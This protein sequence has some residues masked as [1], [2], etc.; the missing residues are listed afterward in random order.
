MKHRVR[1][2]R[3]TRQRGGAGERTQ[4]HEMAKNGNLG[5]VKK[6]IAAR[7]D[8]INKQDDK[9]RTALYE[10][11][12]GGHVEVVKELIA[13]GANMNLKT[14]V[15]GYTPIIVALIQ[16]HVKVVEVLLAAGADPNIKDKYG[17]TPLQMAVKKG[18]MD[19]VQALIAAGADLNIKYDNGM[20]PLNVALEEGNKDLVR[21]FIDGGADININDKNGLTPLHIAIEKGY[22]DIVQK[23][24]DHGADVHKTTIMNSSTLIYAI[25]YKRWDVAL[26]L[27]AAGVDVNLINRYQWN[28]LLLTV[29][30]NGPPEVV[31]ALITAGANV[32]VKQPAKN[33]S[34]RYINRY[35]P[36]KDATSL[37]YA[38]ATGNMEVAELLIAAGADVNV[39]SGQGEPPLII[40]I[41]KGHI[42]VAQLLISTGADINA[43]DNDGSTPA[44]LAARF[45]QVQLL[46]GLLRNEA[47]N[48]EQI[49]S[50]DMTL[51]DFT[52]YGHRQLFFEKGDAIG[53][54]VIA[55]ITTLAKPKQR[56]WN[57][58]WDRS[59]IS[60]LDIVFENAQQDDGKPPPSSNYACCPV[61]LK[62]TERT[63]G[64]MYVLDHNCS[65]SGG[66]YHK[67]LYEKYKH[68]ATGKIMWCALCGRI[69][70]DHRHYH[71]APAQ[72]AIPERFPADD[73]FAPDCRGHIGGGGLPEKVAR[74][75]TL[76]EAFL[77]HL[78]DVD[79][80]PYIQVL[81]E[82]IEAAWNAPLDP[83]YKEISA[84][85]LAEKKWDI[86]LDI[87][88]MSLEKEE[89]VNITKLPDIVKPE[90]ERALV[91]TKMGEG[92]N[93]LG[94]DGMLYK[95]HNHVEETHITSEGLT[96][97]I[98]GIVDGYSNGTDEES[99]GQ[100]F[101][102]GC[103]HKL[104]PQ[105]IK[106][107][108]PDDLYN[109]Y[110]HIFNFKFRKLKG[111]ARKSHKRRK[112]QRNKRIQTKK[113]RV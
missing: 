42:D 56:M 23:L 69:A 41:A 44:F 112:C 104:Y 96:Y 35:V 39:K 91:P 53:K 59:D 15:N 107:I 71:V 73:Y 97:Y 54:Q 87:F 72:G 9:G 63:E 103:K 25:D 37:H 34:L 78:E 89:A 99:L 86:P 12:S 40:S 16:E 49:I 55:L 2:R 93:F 61:C 100:C 57:G 52:N 74:F 50:N 27:I 22:T 111:G 8:I 109:K 101:T 60:R 113:R 28:P 4:L 81:E 46:E 36:V 5:D 13:A 75:R 110:R 31:K 105:D 76:R 102:P 65:E 79:K 88:P 7:K 48:K 83:G 17:L 30:H 106:G 38:A 98:T 18:Y 11:A 3:K 68:P 33:L 1:T 94:Y 77:T 70:S 67:D 45:G 84:R 26:R 14:T 80:K 62:L 90:E 92:Q 32:N 108:V 19:I 85:I 82:V 24:M 66:L 43:N 47:F 6:L 95:F 21:L 58:G 20:T 10:A 29:S 51:Y 64:C